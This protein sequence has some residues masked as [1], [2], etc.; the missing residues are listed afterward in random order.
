MVLRGTV[1]G[2][3]LLALSSRAGSAWAPPLVRVSVVRSSESSQK[4]TVLLIRVESEGLVLGSYQGTLTFDAGALKVDSATVGRDNFR[5]VN[6]NGAASG[7]IRFAGFTTS[8][9]TGS[10][11]VR[12]VARATKP[13]ESAKLNALLEVAG[14]L[15]GKPV[16]KAALVSAHG[17][18]A[19][20]KPPSR[21]P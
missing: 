18:Q 4:R 15:E 13:I 7:T 12:I 6:A 16:S 21:K 17:V 2:F 1:V 9:F 3:A 5:F 11:A 14:D 20:S 19:T 8:G 10:D